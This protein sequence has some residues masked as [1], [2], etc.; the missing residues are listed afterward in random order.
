MEKFYYNLLFA[1]LLSAGL[2]AQNTVLC[3]DSGTSV[4]FNNLELGLYSRSGCTINY[5]ITFVATETGIYRIKVANLTIVSFNI[6]DPGIVN[7]QGQ[8]SI[9][10][11]CF[12]LTTVFNEIDIITPSGS[13][14]IKVSAL[15]P[16]KLISFTATEEDGAAMLRWATSVEV[17]NEG[18]FVEHT[19]DGDGWNELGFVPGVGTTKELQNYDFRVEGLPEGQHYFRLRQVDFDGRF[20]YSPIAS[21]Y[22]EDP[23]N[24][25]KIF[26]NPVG[27]NQELSIRGSFE[28]A[29][30]FNS[31]GQL[32]K[33]I[34]ANDNFSNPQF[35]DLPAGYYQ[36]L[37]QRGNEVIKE[38][39]IIQ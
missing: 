27:R 8:K 6:V 16:V 28:Q 37:I 13:C 18:F 3:G 34:V 15:L 39:L 17:N 24:S 14:D 11:P 30:I 25:F 32:V 7:F 38:K 33:R 21:L 31:A 1:L 12:L 22:L 19:Q 29:Q 9:A 35:L 23:V 36:I 4:T 26:P 10:F 2:Q 20:E 5:D